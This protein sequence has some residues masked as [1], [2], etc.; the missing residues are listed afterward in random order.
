MKSALRTE[1]GPPDVIQIKEV[2]KPVPADDQVLVKVFAASLNRTDWYDLNPPLFIR[3]I[4]G[5]GIRKPKN[6]FLGGDIAGK[7]EAVGEDVSRLKPGDEVFGIS[8]QGLS[9]YTCARESGLAIKPSNLSFEQASAVPIAAITALQGLRDKGRIQTGQKVL[10]HGAS[11]S[12]GTFAVQI[13]KSFGGEVTAVCSTKNVDSVRSLGA[14]KVI[15]YTQE[16]FTKSGEKY[17][18]IIEVNGYRSILTFRRALTPGGTFVMI[19]SSRII[20]ALLQSLILGP[21]LSRTGKKKMAFFMAKV[22]PAD[23]TT[24]KQLIEAGRVK[25]FIDKEYS[26]YEIADAYRYLGEGHARGKIVVD[27]C[28]GSKA[29]G[30]RAV[31]S[32]TG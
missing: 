22:N 2:E 25:P 32:D 13:A 23:L 7:V 28:N 30:R 6:R 14:D 17:D 4:S 18:L 5:G 9:E 24:L 15:D 20:T 3:M 19:G 29:V 1:Y 26:L 8:S 21:L 16:D 27:I 11:G 31:T 10:V 12:V